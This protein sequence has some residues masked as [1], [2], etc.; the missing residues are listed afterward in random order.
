MVRAFA[1]YILYSLGILILIVSIVFR[2]QH[3]PGVINIFRAGITCSAL[4][5]LLI[6]WEMVS[7]KRAGNAAKI[8]WLLFYAPIVLCSFF[9]LPKWGALVFIVLGGI[10]L[11]F[12]RRR[13][14]SGYKKPRSIEFD[15][16]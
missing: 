4:F 10:Y 6:F 12:G 15:S 7:S 5:F 3:W 11:L 14:S 16:I 2:I 1:L 9:V 8:L 13:F